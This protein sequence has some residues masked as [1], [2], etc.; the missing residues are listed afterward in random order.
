MDLLEDHRHRFRSGFPLS[1]EVRDQH[2]ELVAAPA[3]RRVG[4]AQAA[5]EPCGHLAEERIACR[6]AQRSV[7]HLEAI[8]VHE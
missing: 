7:D 2:D 8:E 5:R 3:R 6:V 1:G 4:F